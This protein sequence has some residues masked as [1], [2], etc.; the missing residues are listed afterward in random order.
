MRLREL[1]LA[2]HRETHR[3]FGTGVTPSAFPPPGPATAFDVSRH[4]ERVPLFKETEVDS[5]FATRECITSALQRPG[6]VWP[7]LL[8]CKIYG[9][10]RDAVATLP[11]EDSLNYEC[12]S[13]HPLRIC[14]STQGIPTKYFIIIK[15]N[16]VKRILSLREKRELYS[17]NGVH[18][19]KS[20][21]I[22]P[23]ERLC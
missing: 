21:T 22:N 5:Y 23:L 7:L 13:S 1:E 2:S 12:E 3:G 10:A 6:K 17:I 15:K 20:Q 8:R 19:V 14:V 11:V 4:I 18:L 9:K 16:Q